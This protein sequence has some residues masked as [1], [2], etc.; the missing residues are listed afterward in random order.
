MRG[1]FLS[2]SCRM[3]GS[4]SFLPRRR[5]KGKTTWSSRVSYLGRPLW[6]QRPGPM[7]LPWEWT[8]ERAPSLKRKSDPK[9]GKPTQLFNGRHLSGWRMSDPGST[10]TWIVEN[11]T[12]V[13]P[14]H[15]P[16]LISDAKS[17]DFK[18]HIEFNCA[19]GSNS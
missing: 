15:G 6:G 10:T 12:L 1:P 14:G 8:G 18:L 3:D 9:W 19:P 17:E 11:G 13:S 4:R 16:E 5:K 7:E 2:V